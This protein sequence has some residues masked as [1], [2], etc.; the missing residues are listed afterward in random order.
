MA[1]SAFVLFIGFP[2]CFLYRS[3]KIIFFSFSIDQIKSGPSIRFKTVLSFLGPYIFSF[4]V[5][6]SFFDIF[7]SSGFLFFSLLVLVYGPSSL[8]GVHSIRQLVKLHNFFQ[9]FKD[10]TLAPTLGPTLV[11][12]LCHA[13]FIV[14]NCLRQHFAQNHRHHKMD[15]CYDCREFFDQQATAAA[16]AVTAAATAAAAAASLEESEHV[17][18]VRSNLNIECLN[19]GHMSCIS[20]SFG[21]LV[22]QKYL[23]NY[24][25]TSCK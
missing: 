20:I 3:P 21:V 22:H 10:L 19:V 6:W 12:H 11:C 18:K 7:W 16:T 1:Y 14:L 9:T 8:S 4:S 2:R 17:S 23:V 13:A 24:W 5:L 15:E 25:H